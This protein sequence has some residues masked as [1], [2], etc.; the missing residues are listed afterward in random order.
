VAA[1]WGVDAVPALRLLIKLYDQV[2]RGKVERAAELRLWMDTWGLTPK[3][4]ADRRWAPP[5]P[6]QA[7]KSAEPSAKSRYA[8]LSVVDPA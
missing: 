1:H 4:A 8:H 3:G 6:D 7:D 2:E 5:I